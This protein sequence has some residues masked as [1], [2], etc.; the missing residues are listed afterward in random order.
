MK[1]EAIKP[2]DLKLVLWP[3]EV[4]SRQAEAAE[5]GDWSAVVK[6]MF[7][8]MYESGGCGLAAPQV[9]LGVRLF[10]LNAT[11]KER[12]FFNPSLVTASAQTSEANEGCLSLP[13]LQVRV[14][15]PRKFML[16]YQEDPSGPV[17]KCQFEGMTGRVW[18]HEYDHLQG[19]LITD[20]LAEPERLAALTK[21]NREK[22]SH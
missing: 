18:L 20:Y 4:L 12:A 1:P 2:E 7:R 9:G 13:R 22:I 6:R 19:K 14:A 8:V 17:K 11:G 3:A 5:A 21:L 15:R 10:V 16:T